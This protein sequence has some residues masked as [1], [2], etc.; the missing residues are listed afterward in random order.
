MGFDGAMYNLLAWSVYLLTATIL[1]ACLWPLW[2]RIGNRKLNLGLRALYVWLFFTPAF[3]AAKGFA[4]APA[5]MVAGYSAIQNDDSMML[6][7]GLFYLASAA[8]FLCI[9]VIDR[10]AHAL[11]HPAP[12]KAKQA[13]RVTPRI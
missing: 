2:K 3:S 9:F 4:I 7:A 10:A 8:L 13:Q 5:F 1:Y 12:P 11:L 6:Q